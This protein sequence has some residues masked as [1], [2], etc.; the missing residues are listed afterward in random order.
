MNPPLVTIGIPSFNRASGYL[1]V[2]I[3][4]ALAQSY[5]NIE[6]I[7]SDNCSADHTQDVVQSFDDPRL[8]YFCQEKNIGQLNNTNFI[9]QK[10]RGD[11]LLIYHDDDMID[12]DFIETCMDA[13]DFRRDLG[14]IFTGSRVIDGSGSVLR[15]KEAPVLSGTTEDLIL[16]WYRRRLQMFLC[17]CLFGSKPL[18]EAGGFGAQYDHFHD[19]AAEF[20]CA[21]N[22]GYVSVPTV[23]ASFREH[24]G[25]QTSASSQERWCRSSLA[26]LALACGLAARKQDEVRR[27]GSRTSALRNYRYAFESPTLQERLKRGFEVWRAFGFHQFPEREQVRNLFFGVAS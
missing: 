8:S 21:A 23:K 25:S 12:P 6:V 18:R 17:C 3:E 11:Y 10:A 20:L 7:V 4:S 16:T 26:L 2:A 13:C 22:S 14:L 15:S 27:I 5:A 9:V 1:R 19:V 24:N